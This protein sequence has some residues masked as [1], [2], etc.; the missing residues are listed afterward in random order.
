VVEEV[1]QKSKVKSIKVNPTP[2]LGRGRIKEE[3]G[4]EKY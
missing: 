3:E 2:S 1:S 4:R